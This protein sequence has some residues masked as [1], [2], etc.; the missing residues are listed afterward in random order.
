M[1]LNYYMILFC[2]F[3]IFFIA[4]TELFKKKNLLLD[5]VS[6]EKHKSFAIKTST[7]LTG[8]IFLIFFFAFFLAEKNFFLI[9]FL[10][11]IFFNG[12]LSDV[13][14]LNN[15]KI[16]FLIQLIF[17]F[18][19][20]YSLDLRVFGIGIN[21]IDYYLYNYKYPN[22]IFT[23]FCLLILVN[24]FNFIDG[25]NT[26]SL[27]YFIGAL[28]SLAFVENRYDYNF[29]LLKNNFSVIFLVVL[30]AL[31]L[32]GYLFL[33]DSGSYILGFFLGVKILFI[34]RNFPEISAWYFALLLWYPSFEILFSIIR[35][36]FSKQSAFKPDNEHLH[37][38]IFK[39]LKNKMPY[40]IANPVSANLINFYN[41]ISIFIGSLN[42]FDTKKIIFIIFINIIFYIFIFNRF[43]K[44]NEKN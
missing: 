42:I 11:L 10:L 43:N 16:R 2:I 28:L 5:R 44:L 24:G 26:L 38:R 33:G 22:Y 29:E 12:L 17:V 13:N 7:P 41:I 37:Q 39:K 14:Y 20:I 30:F 32:K 23:I 31:I 40:E 18:F 35:K 15:P 8:G 3:F 4:L 19:A 27:G 1:N 6:S 9:V 21:I 34:S 36:S 25:L